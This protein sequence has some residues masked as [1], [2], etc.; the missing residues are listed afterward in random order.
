MKKNWISQYGFSLAAAGLFLVLLLVVF[1][2]F[3]F[4]PSQL[5]LNSDQLN[6]I[7]SRVLRAQ[8]AVLSEWD[9]SRLGGVP[10]I[11]ALFADAYHPLVWVQF[12][13][14]PARA[15]GFKFILTI[16]VAFCSAM[17]LARSLTKSNWLGALLG[18]LYALSPQ[19]FTYIYG[20]HD[21]KMMVFA[22]APL[23]LLAI[24][25]IVHDGKL[26]HVW[27]LAFSIV[28]MI[29]GS[30]LQLTYL[31]LWGGG[32]YAL[33]EMFT[34]QVTVKQKVARLGAA[35]VALLFG[36][37]ISAFQ[38]LPPYLYTTQ[39]S[40]RG[41]AEKTN[42]G[43][44]VSWSIHQEELGDLLIP[45][46]IGVDVMEVN[47]KTRDIESSA[48]LKYSPEEYRAA[49]GAF[50]WGH[51]P[52]KLNH[53][54]CGA[55]LTFLAFLCFFMPGKKRYAAF[56]FLGTVVALSYALGAHSP[57][58][59]LWFEI[60][61]GVKN[62]RAPSMSLF[63]LPLIAVMMAAPVLRD[64]QDPQKNKHLGKGVFLFGLLLAI[65]TVSRFCWESF[66]GP[67]GFI[68]ILA[69]GLLFILTMN[70]A[71]N[72]QKLSAENL[73]KAL[74]GG[75]NGSSK[76]LSAIYFLPFVFL[77]VVMLSGQ[78][79]LSNPET[80]SYFKPLNLSAMELA[81]SKM[82]PGLLLVL[83]ITAGTFYAIRK[84][85]PVKTLAITLLILGGIEL[86]FTENVFVQNVPYEQY[87]QPN[88]PLT[89]S[90]K[91]LFQDSLQYPR[92]LSLTRTPALAGNIFPVHGL[93]NAEGIHDNELATYR[94]FRGGQGDA[95]F[96]IGLSEQGK[97]RPFLDVANV[98]L[99]IFDGPNRQVGY[100]LNPTAL[101][102]AFLY[103]N[104]VVMDDAQA[105]ETLKTGTVRV[106]ETA[107]LLADSSEVQNDS[108]AAD[109]LQQTV[110]QPEEPDGFLYRETVILSEAP[111]KTYSNGVPQGSVRLVKREKADTQVFEVESDRDAV[112]F[113][114]GNYHPYWKAYV[115]EQPTKVYKAFGTFRAVEIPKGKSVVRM[116]YR[117]EPFHATVK[118]SIIVGILFAL[119]GIGYMI[120]SVR[121]RS[122]SASL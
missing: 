21:G 115:N 43:H 105:I 64:C 35:A 84:K 107:T 42:Y 36:L 120:Y 60:L 4:D 106:Q 1:R 101:G 67:L 29:L 104:V 16:W 38:L 24:R 75:L 77:S 7:G 71:D 51:N 37:L 100:E 20:G 25:K 28:W 6:G 93:R 5:M 52:F 74:S 65:L 31:F 53:D 97:A 113:V 59:K 23:A 9:D 87:I 12:L 83:I 73:W 46:F 91:R 96:L 2:A 111:A 57:L 39:E 119:A 98:G 112:L 15:V 58:F 47:E 103:G 41:T 49:S 90:Y 8:S 121:R 33:Y 109:S 63:W 44:A 62:F 85:L 102:E 82:I 70:L 114:S 110:Q 80:A 14:D 72:N 27:T 22:I 55:V 11:D 79:I 99:I 56:W 86:Y 17:L 116:E 34:I 108:L 40:V 45:G 10:T 92:V 117:S 89:T 61:P 118:I 26:I 68:V 94:A 3:V 48:F 88:N 81:A 32:F 30:H 69:Y 76:I 54:S 18:F 78:K 66:L 13:T 50:Y 95:N 19:Y 122:R